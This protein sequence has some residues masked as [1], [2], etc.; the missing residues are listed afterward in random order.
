[1]V[2]CQLSIINCQLS[3][4]KDTIGKQI[5]DSADS[6]GANTAEGFGR[7]SYKENQRFIRISRG[8]LFE[9]RHWLRRA[10]KRKLITNIKVEKIKSLIDELSPRLNAYLKSIGTKKPTT[11]DK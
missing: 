5:V 2:N 9:T 11:N 7:G 6:I 3:I 4:A 8:S 1:L 10:Y